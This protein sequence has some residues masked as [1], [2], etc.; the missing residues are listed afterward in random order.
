MTTTALNVAQA[1]TR[2]GWKPTDTTKLARAVADFQR[3]WNLGPVL[4]VDGKAGP[5][6]RAALQVS[7]DRLAAHKPTASAHFS[8]AEF[9]CSCG[10]RYDGCA[11]VRVHRGLLQSLEQLRTSYYPRGL[12]IVSGYR[13]PRRNQAVGGASSSQHM[14]GAAADIPPVVP[15]TTLAKR[16]LVAGIG[17]KRSNGLVSHVDRRD[18]SGNNTTGATLD[19][20]T[21]WVYAS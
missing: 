2:L 18:L 6:T 13:C 8:F 10:G 3:G 15:R 21:V 9:R 16:R 12:T 4:A 7:L 17:Y 20:P 14:Y 19:R 11:V 5:K 1:L